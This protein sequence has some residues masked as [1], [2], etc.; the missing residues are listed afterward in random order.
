MKS[1]HGF[2]SNSS[3]SSFLIITRESLT[4]EGLMGVFA[5]PKT[6]PLWAWAED[7]A[8]FIVQEAKPY[9]MEL[10]LEDYGSLAE[11]PKNVRDAL[12]SK[13]ILN[14]VRASSESGDNIEQ[15]LYYLGLRFESDALTLIKEY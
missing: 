1:R 7:L 15:T 14:T 12:D 11:L 9:D 4:K 13:K 8:D 10:A 3:S 5:V 6:S 2:V